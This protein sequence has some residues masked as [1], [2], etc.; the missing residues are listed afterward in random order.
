VGEGQ[1]GISGGWCWWPGWSGGWGGR[2]GSWARGWHGGLAGGGFAG[3]GFE[4]GKEFWATVSWYV[5]KSKEGK[6]AKTL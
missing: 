1:R 5:G 3:G 4:G 2:C 6:A